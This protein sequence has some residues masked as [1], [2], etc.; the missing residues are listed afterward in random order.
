MAFSPFPPALTL[1]S[2]ILLNPSTS[3]I[4]ALD[5][6]VALEQELKAVLAKTA[7]RA[8]KAESDLKLLDNIWRKAKEGARERSKLPAKGKGKEVLRI[9][10]EGSATPSVDEPLY[11]SR[12]ASGSSPRKSTIPYEDAAA[13]IPS[14]NKRDRERDRKKKRKRDRLE[15]SD[16]EMAGSVGR[17]TPPPPPSHPL[18]KKSKS[19]HAQSFTSVASTPS[20]LHTSFSIN[21]TPSVNPHIATDFSLPKVAPGVPPRPGEAGGGGLGYWRPESRT[22]DGTGLVPTPMHV[23]DVNEDFT[24]AKAPV[25]Q[26]P[27]VTFWKEVEGWTKPV[28]EEDIAWL[29]FD[30][31]DTDP[32]LI[33]KLGRH[34]TEVWE[35]EETGDTGHANSISLHHSFSN[36]GPSDLSSSRGGMGLTKWNP[37][38][39][40]E[41]DLAMERNGLGP[42][43]ERLVS[44]LL[45]VPGG[46]D[47]QMQSAGEDEGPRRGAMTS[48][49]TTV[50]APAPAPTADVMDLEERLRAELKA[51][52]L[53]DSDPDFNDSRDDEIMSTLRQCQDLLREQITLNTARKDRL[54]A[55]AKDRLAHQDYLNHLDLL[56]RY[57]SGSFARLFKP[58]PGSKKRKSGPGTES[59]K[60]I[61]LDVPDTLLEKVE[62]RKKFKEAVGSAMDEWEAKEPG[63]IYGLPQSSIYD[64]IGDDSDS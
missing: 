37:A 53:L 14:S 35:D 56:N 20:H 3:Q 44:A 57:I 46:S 18:L 36:A 55:I 52:G 23:T 40:E 38:S 64:N 42:V 15:D 17:P 1:R 6:L 4:P 63:R 26:V 33:P 51:V 21:S 59:E 58:K 49:S 25:N 30:E 39:L 61:V 12:G 22:A 45:E 19:H 34:Y 2:P 62:L 24:N 48:G 13:P 41:A 43:T 5:D 27:T 8:K 54:L 50:P 28:G 10:R 47:V 60:K 11:P 29:G 32:F 7:A 9:K 16:H 31:S